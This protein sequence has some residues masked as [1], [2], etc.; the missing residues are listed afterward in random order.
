[1]PQISW[2]VLYNEMNTGTAQKNISF[3]FSELLFTKNKA[4][5][6]WEFRTSIV[7]MN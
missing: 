5:I 1:M 3:N 6:N 2:V 7:Q 4:L